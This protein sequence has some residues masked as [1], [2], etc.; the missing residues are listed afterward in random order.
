[1]SVEM[2]TPPTTPDR[3]H[4]APGRAY[5]LTAPTPLKGGRGTGSADIT[6][7]QPEEKGSNS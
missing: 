7:E 1:M 5:R 6:E 4:T 3:A 2:S